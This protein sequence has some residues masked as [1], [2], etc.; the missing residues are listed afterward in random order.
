MHLMRRHRIVE[1][2]AVDADF[3]EDGFTLFQ[4]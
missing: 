2:F 1:A 4:G 3:K